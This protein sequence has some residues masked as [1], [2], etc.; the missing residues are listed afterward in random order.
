MESLNDMHSKLL[1]DVWDAVDLKPEVTRLLKDAVQVV[2]LTVQ[3]VQ[4]RFL[5]TPSKPHYLFSVHDID[6]VSLCP[7]SIMTYQG[8]FRITVHCCVFYV[9]L[10]CSSDCCHRS[11]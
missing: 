6:R 10:L 11:P 2:L 4:A 5:P 3:R 8:V 1:K 7:F 9:V